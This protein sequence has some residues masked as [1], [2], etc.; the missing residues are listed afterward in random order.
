MLEVEGTTGM[1]LYIV[2]PE[3]CFWNQACY[4]HLVSP[5]QRLPA[6]LP[7]SRL[8]FAVESGRCEKQWAVG[9]VSDPRSFDEIFDACARNALLQSL[10]K[11][12]S[13]SVHRTKS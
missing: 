4:T 11:P 9:D 13:E 2:S 7:M 10:P 5:V 3:L 1:Q 12:K 8:F 6:A